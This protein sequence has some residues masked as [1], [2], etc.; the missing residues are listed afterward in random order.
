MQIERN[1][2]LAALLLA[3]IF[4]LEVTRTAWISDDAAI[5]LRTVL[6]F[7]NG[8]GPVFNVGERVQAYTHPLWF[9]LISGISLLVRNVFAAT[10]LLSI[11]ISLFALWLLLT[12]V[13]TNVSGAL[14][15]GTVLVLS[16]AYV[17]FATSGLENTLSHLLILVSIL[18]AIRAIERGAFRDLVLFFLSCSLI[19][20]NRPDLLALM[21][22]VAVLIALRGGKKNIAL[23][24]RAIALGAL[25][26]LGWTLFSTYYYGFPFPNTAYAKL[27]TGIALGERLLQGARYVLHSIG[28]DPVTVGFVAA[29]GV[30]GLFATPLSRSIAIGMWLY[31]G[32]ILSIG[33]DFMEGRFFT[34]PLLA[35]AIIVSR[36][37]LQR[38]QAVALGTGVLVIGLVGIKG[39]LLSDA[40][41]DDEVIHPNGIANE[42]GYYYQRFGLLTAPRGTF[43]PPSWVIGERKTEV[44][45]GGLGYA[46]IRNG[47]S[48]HYIDDCALADPLLARLP[49]REDPGWRIGH[50]IRQLPANYQ[51]SVAAGKNLLLDAATRNYY[52][53]IRTITRG[54]LNEPERLRQIL[55]FNL[56]K[57]PRPDWDMYRRN[58]VYASPGKVTASAARLARPVNGGAW[59]APGNVQFTHIL[60]IPLDGPKSFD[61]IDLSADHNDIYRIEALTG[62]GW[63]ELARVGP[64]PRPG[65]ARYQLTL[66]KQVVGATR[67][68]VTARS[69]D[70]KFSVGHLLLK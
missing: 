70:N 51:D 6:N 25:P 42:R 44:T 45:C 56:G 36:S 20:L 31:I 10:F 1:Q 21:L 41:Y 13:A 53:V 18:L 40:N 48:V 64:E 11:C 66:D 59:D 12:K 16:K 8:Y 55:R 23:L 4:L 39:T 22:P 19:Y 33:G 9:F 3:S 29:G 27:G 65:M 32:Y 58:M 61:H 52:E 24:L 37:T 35:A 49:A 46:G 43:D 26:V 69:G 38:G 63:H 57:V 17:D 67:I 34:A 14:I 54:P 30:I 60:E 28:R 15:A 5:T 7:L 68:R 62:S 47:P 2:Y 50:F